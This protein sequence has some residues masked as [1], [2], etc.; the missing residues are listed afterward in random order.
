MKCPKCQSNN[1]KVIDSRDT[2]GDWTRRR[3]RVCIS[4]NHRWTTTE[5][6][7]E[8]VNELIALAQTH[9]AI[10][11]AYRDVFGKSRG[12]LDKVFGR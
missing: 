12:V 6:P 4:C 7:T 3:R 5:I 9:L 11:E 2:H 10:E 1:E 8:M